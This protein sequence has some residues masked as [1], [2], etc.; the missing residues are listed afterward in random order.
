M[1]AEK[2]VARNYNFW[3]QKNLFKLIK[4]KLFLTAHTRY[5]LIPCVDIPPCN[6]GKPQN[7]LKVSFSGY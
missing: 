3:A 7:R 4:K 5:F 6:I 2:L 1:K